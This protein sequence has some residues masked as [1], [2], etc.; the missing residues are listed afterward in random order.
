MAYAS[1]ASVIDTQ[2]EAEQGEKQKAPKGEP[3]CGATGSN[4]C[5]LSSKGHYGL[6]LPRHVNILDQLVAALCNT[7]LDGDPQCSRKQR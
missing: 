3:G 2:D 5:R 6:E 1:D 4:A 7:G